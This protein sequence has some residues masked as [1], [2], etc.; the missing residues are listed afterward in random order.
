MIKRLLCLLLGHRFGGYEPLDE[1]RMPDKFFC[2]R[3][4]KLNPTYEGWF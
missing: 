4:K 2:S 1:Q 3:C